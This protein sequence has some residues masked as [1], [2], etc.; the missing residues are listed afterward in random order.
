M[1]STSWVEI[2][3]GRDGSCHFEPPTDDCPLFWVRY[4]AVEG[5][6]HTRVPQSLDG[7]SVEI[8]STSLTEVLLTCFCFSWFSIVME[9][10]L[11]SN[12]CVQLTLLSQCWIT[13]M[14]HHSQ[15]TDVGLSHLL[16]RVS[17]MAEVHRQF[18]MMTSQCN[19]L[20]NPG[21]FLRFLMQSSFLLI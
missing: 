15:L 13:D 14:S 12:S 16:S 21:Y 19:C 20:M 6:L 8:V 5:L 10:R 4:R 11:T 7:N 18:L 3:P 9:P 1:L 2:F 17:K